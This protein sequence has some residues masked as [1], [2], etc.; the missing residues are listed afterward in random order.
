MDVDE[1]VSW[2]GCRDRAAIEAV[3]H[4]LEAD[5]ETADGEVERLRA[6]RQ[7]GLSLRRRGR[8]R[9]A[10]VAVHRATEAALHACVTSGIGEG[11]RG[12]ATLVARAAGDAALGLVAGEHNANTDAVLR[13]FLGSMILT[14]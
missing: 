2:L 12:R 14:S 7:L 9:Q 3:V 5:R 10:G 13:P 4:A 11:Q 8:G 6:T 1:F